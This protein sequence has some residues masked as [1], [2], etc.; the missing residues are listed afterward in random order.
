MERKG[1]GRKEQNEGGNMK[2]LTLEGIESNPIR[3]TSLPDTSR[4]PI[5]ER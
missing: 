5:Y 3:C 1:K 2:T 4:K